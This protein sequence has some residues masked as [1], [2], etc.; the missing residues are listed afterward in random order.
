MMQPIIPIRA[1]VPN[2]AIPGVIIFQ[3]SIYESSHFFSSD[4]KN[5][6]IHRRPFLV[7]TM[8]KPMV[9]KSAIV[10]NAANPGV[11]IT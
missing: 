2:V 6:L 9:P 4:L 5:C 10:P 7:L 1:N 8:I 3:Y 11:I